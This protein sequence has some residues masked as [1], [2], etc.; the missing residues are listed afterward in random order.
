[1]NSD[2][3][4]SELLGVM[5]LIAIFVTA[6]AIVGVVLLSAPPGDA[7]PA[8]IARSVVEEDGIIYIYHDGGD[9]LEKEHFA[10]LVE[11]IPQTG[12]FKLID[13]SGNEHSTWTT[14]ET[15]QTLVLDNRNGVPASSGVPASRDPHIQI[16]GEGVGRT[17][18][19]WLLHDI[20]N[21]T[22]MLPVAAFNVTPTE[23]NAPLTVQFMDRSIGSVTTW[24]WDFG[25]GSTSTEQNLTYTYTVPG[26]YSVTLNASNAY[27]YSV[28]APVT[29]TVLESPVAGFTVDPTEGNAPLTVQ[30]TDQ[31]TGNVTAW[32]WDFGDGNTSTEQSPTHTYEGSGTYTITLNASNAYGYDI[33]AP[34]TIT[35]LESP[36]A[37]FTVDPTEGNAPLTVQCTD[38]S[39]GDITDWFWDFGDGTNSTEQHPTHTY[40]VPNTYT[41]TLNASNAYGYGISAPITITVLESPTATFNATP[42]EGNVPLAVQF[43]DQSTGNV[44]NW[45]WDF[46][47]GATSTEQHPEHTYTEP[48]NYTVTLNA[49]NAYGYDVSAPTQIVALE[50][51]IA[52]FNAM[53][54]EGNAPLAVQF[55]DESTG[56]VT[57]WL[58]NFGDGATSTE[59]NPSHTYATAGTYAV[60]LNASNTY[61]YSVS[62][63]I[64]ITVLES[65]VAAFNVTPTEGNA[66]LEVQ[67]TDTSIGDVTAWLWDFGDGNTSIEQNPA[68][69]YAAAGNYSVTL[70]ASNTYGYSISALV[71]ITVLMPPAANFTANVTTGNAPLAVQFTDQSTGNVTAWLWDFGDGNTSAVKNPI[72]TY[73]AV[74]NYTVTLN[75]SNAYGNSTLARPNYI[76]VT[77][78]SFI[79]FI[80]D[81]NV[82]VY[83]TALQFNGNNVNGPGATVIVTGGLKTSDL[84]GG[85]SINVSNIYIDGDA[86]L[87]GGSAGLGSK[88]EPGAIYINGDLNLMSGGRDIYGDVY[89]SGNL[90]LKDA[91]IH[92]NMYVQGKADLVGGEIY[93][94]LYQG[95]D[96]YLK[97]AHTHG[98]VYVDG[99]VELDWTPTVYGKIEYTGILTKKTGY[100]QS[101]LDKCIQTPDVP[102]IPSFEMP[103]QGIPPTKPASWYTT[104][105]QNYT[106]DRDLTNN[107]K[108]FADSYTSTS[109]NSANNVIII[110]YDGDISI[111]GQWSTVT[112]VF[113]APQGKVTFN[114]KSLEGVVIARDGFFVTSGDTKVTF[115][116]VEEYI[117][118]PADYPF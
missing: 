97:D 112:G 86:T 118:N 18:S 35:V 103:D 81:E 69:T 1:M 43:T 102:E 16:V 34:I 78:K 15:G 54:T 72:H 19:D 83:G 87:N 64:T 42:T 76:Q 24:L 99:N 77:E 48:G 37:G 104:P 111:T 75:V 94:D 26:T 95:G 10:I 52:A 84:N 12:K 74:G 93:G 33:S 50:P 117:S 20:G 101:I 49:S 66:P 110:A 3:A 8:M 14:W 56:N 40:A 53:P 22:P 31:S 71:T 62:A 67:C 29:I 55:I 5:A 68:H 65:P 6:A 107:L 4:I 109:G 57:A 47:D 70:N 7:P 113:F 11:G 23:G 13:A 2:T 79:D 63:P 96:L 51:P 9:P 91:R 85:A 44:T 21:I 82:F 105:P 115:K 28:S 32:L 88:T 80:I 73:A 90:Y 98:D 114:G 116:N 61:G 30:C 41:V 92:G 58:W 27:G 25:D 59:Q 39:T 108:I 89:V 17:G 106:L 38:A 60:T 100:H 36:V 46:G 45:L